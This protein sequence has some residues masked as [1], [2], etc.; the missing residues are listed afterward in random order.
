MG[1]TSFRATHDTFSQAGIAAY[2]IL[3]N[4]VKAFIY[5][6][7][8]RRNQKLLMQIPESRES[9]ILDGIQQAKALIADWI[10]Q[11]QLRL[12]TEQA[13]RLLACYGISSVMTRKCATLAALENIADEIGYP[14]ALKIDCPELEHAAKVGGVKLNIKNVEQLKATAQSMQTQIAKEQP[15]LNLRGFVLQQMAEHDYA[16]ELRITVACDPTFGPVFYL[17]EGAHNWQVQRD[18]VVGFPPLNHNLARYLIVQA[19]AEDKVRDRHR[20]RALDRDGLATLLCRLSQLLLDHPEVA[21]LDINPVLAAAEQFCVLDINLQLQAHSAKQVRY[22]IRP[23]PK[24]LEKIVTLKDG[25]QVLIRPIRSEDWSTQLAF[26]EALSPEDRYKRY[27]GEVPTLDEAQLAKLTQIDY[28]REMSLI[29]L[30]VAGDTSDQILAVANIYL[31]PD[32]SEAEFAIAVRSDLKSKGLG[33]Q[34]ML[35]IIDYCRS[36]S[37]QNLTGMTM[38][39]NQSMAI[40]AKNLG[41]ELTRDMEERVLLMTLNMK[42]NMNMKTNLK[43]T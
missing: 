8:H 13:N 29:A 11:R 18:A 30:S 40:L 19:L 33:K 12:D 21:S 23:Y 25:Q 10:K 36:Q 26:D 37:V 3:E 28:E 17:G 32:K 43:S 24:D 5:M 15:D 16:H 38:L 34:L 7:R 39:T 6:L 22:A 41:F 31:E 14:L 1:D 20:H 35:Q 42:T 2:R 4:A 27:F 9:D